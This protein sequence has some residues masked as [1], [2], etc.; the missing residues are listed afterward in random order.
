TYVPMLPPSI[1]SILFTTL[2]NFFLGFIMFSIIFYTASRKLKFR[3]SFAEFIAYYFF[4]QPI[5][6][7]VL[8]AG[9][10]AGIFFKDHKIDWKL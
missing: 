3:F 1:T 5:S 7:L 2:T 10:I 6:F 4:Y 8:F 9:I